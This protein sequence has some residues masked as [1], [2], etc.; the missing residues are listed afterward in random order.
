MRLTQL[1]NKDWVLVFPDDY[2]KKHDSVPLR[3]MD[4]ETFMKVWIHNE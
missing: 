3:E 2:P 1:D 4:K